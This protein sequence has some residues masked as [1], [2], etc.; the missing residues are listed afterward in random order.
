VTIGNDAFSNNLLTS[1]VFSK[2][3][4][5]I[6]RNAF[7]ENELQSLDFPNSLTSIGSFAFCS[8]RIYSITLPNS[9]TEIKAGVFYKNHLPTVIIPSTVVTIESGAFMANRLESVVFEDDS[10]LI[11]IEAGAFNDNG[12]EADKDEVKIGT[13]T[14]NSIVL[15]ESHKEACEYVGWTDNNE[16]FYLANL[17]VTN[18]FLEY[19]A[20]FNP[21]ETAAILTLLDEND[22]LI[23]GLQITILADS[24]ECILSNG[25]GFST[26]SDAI[27]VVVMKNLGLDED[28]AVEIEAH[29]YQSEVVNVR[30]GE[31]T[32]VI[33]HR[34]D[35]AAYLVTFIV[36]DGNYNVLEGV[37]IIIDGITYTTDSFG[38][39]YLVNKP[40]GVISYKAIDAA[41]FVIE[42]ALTINGSNV[43]EDIKFISTGVKLKNDN[44]F[45]VYPNPASDKVTIESREDLIDS[46]KLYDIKGQLIINQFN[47]CSQ[48]V[49]VNLTSYPDGVYFIKVNTL[50][51]N[52]ETVK[53]LKK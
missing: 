7:Y 31:F 46:Y 41:G 42:G 10:H 20:E 30:S 2:S 16:N 17:E 1:I 4:K 48:Q 53:L 18:Y 11:S 13:K 33:L 43:V 28:C 49:S 3:L 47:I 38:K 50:K 23:K 24:E 8:N 52:S 26:I 34:L 6:G 14:L 15:P 19:K 9:L 51:G 22:N 39:V 32:D 40:N 5:S 37:Q 21:Q 44:F 25:Q 35:E 36:S 12:S 45:K 29:R 27:G